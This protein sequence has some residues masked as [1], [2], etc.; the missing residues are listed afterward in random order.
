[1][2]IS[3]L[4]KIPLTSMFKIIFVIVKMF[5]KIYVNMSKLILILD[6]MVQRLLLIVHVLVFTVFVLLVP[7]L[8]GNEYLNVKLINCYNKLLKFSKFAMTNSMTLAP[9]MWT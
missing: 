1:M 2:E 4:N 8:L 7:G 5:L 3:G 6:S 9:W